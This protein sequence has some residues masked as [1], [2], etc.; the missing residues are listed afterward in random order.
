MSFFDQ[1][2]GDLIVWWRA[3]TGITDYVGTSTSSRIYAGRAKQASAKSAVGRPYVV[4]QVGGGEVWKAH[5]NT[6]G[7][8]RSILDVWCYSS[9]ESEA[10]TMA[11]VIQDKMNVLDKTLIGYTWVD[12]CNA[13]LPEVDDV[14]PWVG[15]DDPKLFA[16]VVCE[17]LHST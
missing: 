6:L 15:S 4:Y 13:E 12:V 5:C 3:D 7:L 10:R 9:K 8:K 1:D 14:P 16:R 17:I 11:Q 2:D